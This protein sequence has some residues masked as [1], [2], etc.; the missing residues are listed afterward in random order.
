MNNLISVAVNMFKE[1]APCYGEDGTWLEENAKSIME[2][3]YNV[4]AGNQV[5]LHQYITEM[6]GKDKV[7]F[8][9][10]NMLGYLTSH[11]GILDISFETAEGKKVSAKNW[12]LAKELGVENI[13]CLT[14]D[15]Q[16]VEKSKVFII[17]RRNTRMELENY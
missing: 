7:G 8:V 5:H 17:F 10:A 16:E 9:M 12:H 15:G 13:K 11:Y 4:P 2:Y 3:L 6:Y 1:L 14:E